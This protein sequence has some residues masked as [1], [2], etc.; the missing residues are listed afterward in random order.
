MINKIKNVLFL[1]CLFCFVVFVVRLSRFLG[2]HSIGRLMNGHML[3][4]MFLAKK[5]HITFW[6]RTMMGPQAGMGHLMTVQIGSVT[7][8]SPAIG[9]FA[10]VGTF[11]R[12]CST[13][14]EKSTLFS[15]GFMA[16][17]DGT[18]KRTSTS[19]LLLVTIEAETSLEAAVAGRVFA[20]ELGVGGGAGTTLGGGRE[21][22]E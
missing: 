2:L 4:Q 7:K 22:G 13:M 6:K 11:S 9:E 8:S 16:T 21:G 3:D 20:A 18:S 19:V 1:F 12:V 10:A 17:I 5:S 15:K 14:A